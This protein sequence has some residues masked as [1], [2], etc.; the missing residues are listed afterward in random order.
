VKRSTTTLVLL[1]LVVVGLASAAYVLVHQ[2]AP[3]PFRD[4]YALNVELTA[5]DG[6]E[7]GLGQ[8][9]LVSGVQVGTIT[10]LGLRGG[11]ARLTVTIDRK[12]L[13]SV[14]RGARAY[15]EPITPL[16]DMQLNLDPGPAQ[17]PRLAEGA[18]ID[19]S[20]TRVPVPLSDLTSVLDSD[21]RQFLGSLMNAV[22]EGTRGRGLGMRRALQTLGPTT[23]Q[24]RLLARALGARRRELARLVHNV[25][26]LTAAAARS[27]RLDDLVVT[28]QRTLGAVAAQ[29]RALRDALTLLPGTLRQTSSTLGTTANFARRLEPTL[30][31]LTP[32]VRRLPATLRGLREFSIT[33]RRV[34]R[35]DGTPFV[36]QATP[37]VR[38]LSRV[39][40][41]LGRT[42]PALTRTMQTAEY[43]LNVA[44]YNPPGD[45][46]GY[47][48]WLPW[49]LHN[50]NSTF[51]SADA[52]GGFGRA[53]VVF[54]CRNVTGTPLIDA[55]VSVVL[56]VGDVCPNTPAPGA[57]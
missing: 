45:D 21:T 20:R 36:D 30:Q 55:Y 54:S 38:Q 32:V 39:V 37:T 18:T 16:K 29:D 23:A 10:D 5:A 11:N 48:F 9:V 15:L 56:G 49:F 40:G 2:R 50:F 47:L 8:P 3:V 6:V 43:I 4:T 35:S 14:H 7:P 13:P 1:A 53:S 34:L 24:A 41:S 26:R 44:A 51:S 46:E 27:R 33:G 57:R 31:K 17:A 25:S 42:A 19:V 22:G 12:Q 28:S 52:H